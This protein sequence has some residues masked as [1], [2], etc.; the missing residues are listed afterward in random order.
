MLI[1]YEQMTLN[2]VRN[3]DTDIYGNY[4]RIDDIIVRYNDKEQRILILIALFFLCL[5]L[6][7]SIPFQAIIRSSFFVVWFKKRSQETFTNLGSNREKPGASGGASH[8]GFG[9]SKKG[10]L[11]HVIALGTPSDSSRAA[12]GHPVPVTSDSCRKGVI[13]LG[14]RQLAFVPRFL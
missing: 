3:I 10:S 13:R 9:V 7:W 1:M 12:L 4:V 8:P 2:I 11:V 5:L 6:G 14:F